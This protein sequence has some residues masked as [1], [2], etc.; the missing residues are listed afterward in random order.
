MGG[1]TGVR[2]ESLAQRGATG[3]E[4]QLTAPTISNVGLELGDELETEVP[5]SNQGPGGH[6]E[7][8]DLELQGVEVL[9]GER[10]GER[11]VTWLPIDSEKSCA[12][13]E[14]REGTA[15][16]RT[17]S[18]V[19]PQFLMGTGTAWVATDSSRTM[20]NSSAAFM[21]EWLESICGGLEV[22]RIHQR[23]LKA[24]ET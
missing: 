5:A 20:A 7:P 21:M 22:C 15:T 12:P 1:G 17:G 8:L 13:F 11:K 18:L 4:E 10:S 14:T 24:Y 6:I 16:K 3:L 9:T 23:V 2:D 19:E